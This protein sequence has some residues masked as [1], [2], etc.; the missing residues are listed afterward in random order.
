[1]LFL[2]W[3]FLMIIGGIHGVSISW[4]YIGNMP[5]NLSG[6]AY[7]FN[8]SHIMLI[9]GYD[10]TEPWTEEIFVYQP[11]NDIW[12]KLKYP[13]YKS[14]QFFSIAASGV[15]QILKEDNQS[16]NIF[17]MGP[18]AQKSTDTNGW[19]YN[20]I[21][22]IWDTTSFSYFPDD[23]QWPCAVSDP[24]TNIIYIIG[25]IINTENSN[26]GEIVLGDV[27]AYNYTN[28]GSGWIQLNYTRMN[29][30]RFDGSCIYANDSIYYFGGQDQDVNILNTIEKY[31][32]NENKWYTLNA[33]LKYGRTGNRN[34]LINN[35]TGILIIGGTGNNV[36][37]FLNSVEYFDIKSETIISSLETEMK[38]NRDSAGAVTFIDDKIYVFG[39]LNGDMSALDTFEVATVNA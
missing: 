22:N 2:L 36:N 8:E 35:D 20:P 34:V 24:R 29:T 18:I 33:T 14:P 16:W 23:A 25:G 12:T 11:I 19:V 3:N 6:M 17:I 38:Y 4:D 13:E 21:T 5:R 7:G 27:L 37:E 28:S 31:S 30:P 32:I 10:V 1:M 39:G 26:H 9:G 15:T